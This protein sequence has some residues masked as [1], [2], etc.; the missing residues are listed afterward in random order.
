MIIE[1]HALGL[2]FNARCRYYEGFKGSLEEPP[3][4][5]NIEILSLEVVPSGEDA[6]FL[7]ESNVC[8]QLFEAA[9]DQLEQALIDDEAAS[10]AEAR[11]EQRREEEL[12][13]RSC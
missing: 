9:Y 7:L 3:E 6:T 10:A 4:P 1:F 2:S 11:F 13:C 12:M 5:H 8:D